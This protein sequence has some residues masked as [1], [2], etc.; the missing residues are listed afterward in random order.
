MPDASSSVTR[1]LAPKARMWTPSAVTWAWYTRASIGFLTWTCW[2]NITLA[3]TRLQGLS[4]QNAEEKA[5]TL[6]RM[7]G[8]ESKRH[9]MSEVLSG[10]QRQRIAIC[11]CLAGEPQVMLF[12]EPTS[13]LD[14]TMVG[15]VLATIRMLAKRDMTM[16]IVTHKMAFAREVATRVLYFNQGGIYEEG[17]PEQLFDQPQRPGTQAFVKRLKT[18]EREIT[19][20]TFDFI[21]VSTDIE[22]FGRRQLLSQRQIHHLQMVFE[23][24]CVQ[25]LLA[26][27]SRASPALLRRRLRAG[28]LLSGS[29][30]LWRAC[31]RPLYGAAGRAVCAHGTGLTTQHH[32]A[33]E[34]GNQITLTL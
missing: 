5:L 6:L 11:R 34:D 8:L 12:D 32:W 14:P 16:L 23:E 4:Q 2:K 10:G 26:R 21:A 24:L 29:R 22:E 30:L 25:T 17:T 13:A 15:E 20:P 7:V 33:C 27:G 1:K 3:P 31:L 28:R 9:A 19:S 18:F